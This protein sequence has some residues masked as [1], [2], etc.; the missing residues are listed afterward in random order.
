MA[1]CDFPGSNATFG[2]P[3]DLDESQC[4]SIRAFCGQVNGGPVD[5]ATIVVV[6]WRPDEQDL[7]RLA[8]GEPLY[9]TMFGGLAPHVITTIFSQDGFSS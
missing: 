7:Q 2:P 5:G 8:N 1:P 3:P 4:Q 6:A 9:L